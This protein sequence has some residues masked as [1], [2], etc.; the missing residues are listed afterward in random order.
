MNPGPKCRYRH[1]GPYAQTRPAMPGA[2][3]RCGWEV[4]R[5]AWRGISGSVVTG[6][7]RVEE[8]QEGVRGTVVAGL[9]VRGCHACEGLLLHG[10]VGV[11]VDAWVAG[12]SWPF[13][14]SRAALCG[15]DVRF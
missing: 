8:G 3:E 2:V 14:E 6:S 9:A 1:F 13:L 4:G 10:H 7:E 11:Q 12:D 5:C 15:S